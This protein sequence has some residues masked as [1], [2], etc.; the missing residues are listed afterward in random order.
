MQGPM[1]YTML[2]AAGTDVAGVMRISPN[3]AVYLSVADVDATASQA[4]SLGG[5]VLVP[6]TDIPEIGRFATI[7]DPQGA[8]FSVFASA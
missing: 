4:A 7:Q 1:D 6:G 8:V 3:W 5:T 2:K